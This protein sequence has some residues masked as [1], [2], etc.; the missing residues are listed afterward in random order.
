MFSILGKIPRGHFHVACSGGSDSMVMVDF[1]RK[2]P[3]NNFDIIHFNHGTDCCDEAEEFVRGFCAEN[4]I[5]LHV[6]RISKERRTNES[7]EEYWRR[8]R[9]DFFS[10]FSNEPILLSHHLNDCIETWVMTSLR[11][12]PLLIPYSNPKYNIIRPFLTVPKSEIAKW[13][14]NHDV[15]YVIDR[16]NFDTTINRNYVRLSMM[17]SIYTL[18]PG[19]EKTIRRKVVEEFGK[20][21]RLSN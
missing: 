20:V 2:Y 6:G 1:L 11:G 14:K 9:Y 16:S 7:R 12:N 15:K 3:K 4:G 17:K 10:K 21:T 19:I 5:E 13:A 18:N 8:C